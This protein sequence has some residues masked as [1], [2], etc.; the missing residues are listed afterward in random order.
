M[1][2]QSVTIT[3]KVNGGDTENE[4]TVLDWILHIFSV[5]WKVLFAVVPPCR[6]CGGHDTMRL[7]SLKV[8]IGWLTFGIALIF[9]GLLTAG[10]H[11]NSY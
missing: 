11:N 3:L 10:P 5:F 8:V 1:I 9:I 2:V 4:A 7:K 6:F